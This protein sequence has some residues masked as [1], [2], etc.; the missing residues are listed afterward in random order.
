MEE[1]H[2]V[3]RGRTFLA[4]GDDSGGPRRRLQAEARVWT[5]ET[6]LQSSGQPV[7]V[8][9]SGVDGATRNDWVGVY[10]PADGDDRDFLMYINVTDAPTYT[11]GHGR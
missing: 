11:A 8:L 6:S 1:H 10:S 9:W 2:A 4:P 5:F 7:T 3:L